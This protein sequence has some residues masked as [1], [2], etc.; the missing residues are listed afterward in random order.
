[1]KDILKEVIGK[2]EFEARII[3]EKNGYDHRVS[4]ADGVAYIV[5]ADFRTDRLDLQLVNGVVI[6]ASIQ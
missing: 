5:T 3:A 1:M 4:C 2:T 6:N